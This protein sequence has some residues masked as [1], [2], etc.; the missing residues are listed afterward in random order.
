MT[1]LPGQRHLGE[2]L[3]GPPF[4]IP[5]CYISTP[6]ALCPHQMVFSVCLALL[7]SHSA[8]TSVSVCLVLTL[9]V[10]H[11]LCLLLFG[12]LVFLTL[13]HQP[14]LNCSVL[15]DGLFDCCLLCSLPTLIPW[16]SVAWIISCFSIF[17]FPVF[18][19]ILI[20]DSYLNPLLYTAFG[21]SYPHSW[22]IGVSAE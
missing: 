22:Q 14:I 7:I 21:S 1:S 3:L 13:W 9:P 10:P 15:G 4:C 18:M 17:P 5:W 11:L 20:K 2:A 16:L 19:I 12:L 8:F 6:Q